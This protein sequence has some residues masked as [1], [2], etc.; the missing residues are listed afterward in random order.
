[1][2]RVTLPEVLTLEE[3]SEYLRQ[4][5]LVPS[6]RLGMHYRRLRL[7][8]RGGASYNS[9]QCRALEREKRENRCQHKING[10]RIR[11]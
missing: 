1:M 7:L 3:V 2:E 5:V 11:N 9:F 10:D 4:S 8:R 6:L